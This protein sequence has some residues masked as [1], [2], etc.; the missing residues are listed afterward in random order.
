M[1]SF[2]IPIL[3]ITN[4]LAAALFG[5]YFTMSFSIMPGLDLTAPFSAILANQEIGHATQQSFFVVAL[6]GTPIGLII[7]IIIAS[8]AKNPV[9][10]TWLIIAMIG[11]IG[12]LVVTLTLN[13]PLNQILDGLTIA[14]DQAGLAQL[15]ADYSID[16]QKWNL[17]RLATSGLTVLGLNV[18]LLKI[19]NP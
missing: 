16:W 9:Q 14:P 12:M 4:L 5:F 17:L 6:L 2:S 7:A 8:Q 19:A 1:R 15:W 3:L 10:R 11:W 18:A 13:V